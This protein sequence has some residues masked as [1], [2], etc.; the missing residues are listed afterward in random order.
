MTSSLA[1]RRCRL[2]TRLL[3]A[4]VLG[5]AAARPALA[6]TYVP[7]SDEALVD[8]APLI[9]V[10]R[11]VEVEGTAGSTLVRARIVSRLKG[12]APAPV[13]EIDL[14]G[15]RQ[16][17][18]ALGAP[19]VPR[20]AA[21]GR[22]LLFL[23]PAPGSPYGRYRLHQLALGAFHQVESDGV[24]YALRDLAGATA[25][26][27]GASGRVAT[28]APFELRGFDVFASWVEARA[29]GQQ[30]TGG[31][32]VAVSAEKAAALA[33]ELRGGAKGSALPVGA[34]WFEFDRG[35]SVSF[36]I[37]GDVPEESADLPSA[38]ATALA[39]WNDDPATAVDLRL[40]G[41]ATAAA[42]ATRLDGENS[43][44]MSDPEG[45]LS[46]F[47]CAFGG[48]LALT[49]P[50]TEVTSE[51]FRGAL[52]QR[53][54]EA[55]IVTNQGIGCYL[56]AGGHP[57]D[58]LA[59][60]LTHEIGHALGLGHSCG[61]ASSGPCVAGSGRDGALMR[62]QI[63]N[64]GR[65]ARLSDEDRAA[66][67]LLYGAAAPP[68]APTGLA[69]TDR[70]THEIVLTWDDNARGEIGYAIEAKELGGPFVL[71]ATAPPDSTTWVVDGLAPETGY[72]FRLRAFGPAGPSADSNE[73]SAVTRGEA[74]ACIGG[75]HELC[76]DQGRFRV[77][78]AFAGETGSGPATPGPAV[79][80]QSGL[81]WFFTPGNWELA[82]KVLDG[83]RVNG[84][85]WIFFAALTHVE[86]TVT[87]TDTRT[88]ATK[89]Y[90]RLPGSPSPPV[91]DNEALAVC[92]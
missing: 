74:G 79:S 65:G 9:A 47:S 48:V 91:T 27:A 53:L 29:R 25:L 40:A 86:H 62:A 69:A 80:D 61:D 71:R 30:S 81:F 85:Y 51:E 55:D 7:V 68:A 16:A 24:R 82:L 64:D 19:G 70:S 5:A 23:E 76:L 52:L 60:L 44:V 8:R 37:R 6:F 20:F 15:G 12:V 72:R 89:V 41:T 90:W 11:I 14:P 22:A 13:V 58:T 31:Y 66:L 21:G 1:R 92:P 43:L 18:V 63:H 50:V 28:P 77:R 17:G 73:A 67:S 59:E 42:G 4:A 26:I 2:A 3:L 84:H 39:A 35:A 10:V 46:P 56:A 49:L 54:V 83:C 88:G 38:F 34:R 87:V 32:R 78:A 45:L 57:E 33:A 75:E 36:R